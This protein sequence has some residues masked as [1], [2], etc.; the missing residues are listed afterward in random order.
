MDDEQPYSAQSAKVV[1]QAVLVLREVMRATDQDLG[2]RELSRRLGIGRS[3]VQRILVAL[4]NAA[5]L[6]FDR[7]S[8]TFRPDRVL[9]ELTSLVLRRGGLL[10]VARPHLEQL[11]RHT[12][13][14][15]CLSVEAHDLRVTLDQLDSPHNLRL[16]TDIGVGSPLY[17]GAAGR[18]LLAFMGSAERA[19]YLARTPLVSL[20]GAT[21]TERGRLLDSL[22]D[23]R[24]TGHAISHGE[25]VA[26]GVAVA[27]P[28]LGTGYAIASVSVFV[29]EQRIDDTDARRLGEEVVATARAIEAELAM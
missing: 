21:I 11:W 1:E 29:P 23:I 16:T 10:T 18:V 8:Q 12:K 20:T 2:V 24:R 26:G 22:E 25:R 19:A 17:A 28:V 15:V 9:L 3:T 7:R 14:T 27:A 6:R 5:V 4:Q 13:E